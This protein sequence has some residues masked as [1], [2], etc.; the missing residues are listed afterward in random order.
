MSQKSDV[1]AAALDVSSGGGSAAAQAY[2]AQLAA[3]A[4][5]SAVPGA[6][7]VKSTYGADEPRPAPILTGIDART[8][9]RKRV[10]GRA[11]ILLQSGGAI[12]VGKMV[13]ISVSGACVLLDDMVPV[14]KTCTL[15]CDIFQNGAR[16]VFSVP[17]VSVYGVLASGHGFKVGFQ[18]GPRSPATLKAISD[19]MR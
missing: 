7:Q 3:D 2:K 8:A 10:S 9:E 5:V 4:A 13:D 6:V 17:A 1:S 19:I 12:L 18:F 11:R 15:E 16:Q 14:K